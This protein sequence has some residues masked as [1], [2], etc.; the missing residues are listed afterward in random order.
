M[1]VQ[2]TRDDLDEMMA[3]ERDAFAAPIRAS[4]ATY[5]HRFDLGHIVLGYR[6]DRL[7]GIISFSYGL[8]DPGDPSSL[9]DNFA[10]W[11]NQPVPSGFD[12]AFIY[13][14]GLR[15]MARGT[16]ILPRLI[17][18]ALGRAGRDGCIQVVAEGPVPS[19]A[20]ND[21]IRAN[22]LIRAALDHHAAGGEP[23]PQA[24]MFRD[25]H[26][27]LY[28]RM[29]DCSIIRILPDFLPEDVASGGFRVMLFRKLA[30]PGSDAP[31][32]PRAETLAGG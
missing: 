24:L 8:F 27:A 2:L 12:T 28:R 31:Q 23:P 16:G 18:G 22:P 30:A 19:Y 17:A 7:D 21:H 5:L 1:L 6:S 11:S 26:L 32:P 13:N 9:P 4:A 15:P 14:L 29:A 25:P 10:D 3:L 20:G